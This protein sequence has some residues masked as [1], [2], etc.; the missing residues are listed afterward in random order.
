MVSICKTGGLILKDSAGVLHYFHPGSSLKEI[1]RYVWN[2]NSLQDFRVDDESIRRQG[3]KL[4]HAEVMEEKS[5]RLRRAF[6][7]YD[8]SY[9]MELEPV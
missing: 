8:D 3:G 2:S 1:A 5:H 7:M 6:S 4:V 9:Y